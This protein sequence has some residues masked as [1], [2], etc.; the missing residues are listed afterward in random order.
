MAYFAY[1][2]NGIV[3]H[4]HYLDEAN[5]IHEKWIALYRSDVVLKDT[6]G[7]DVMPGDLF[8]EEKFYKKNI[9]TGETSLVEDGV[10]VHP[11]AIRFA[12]I[13]DGELIGQWGV[14][15]EQFESQ[16]KIDEFINDIL[17][18]EIIEIQQDQPHLVQNG[19]TYN[20]SN[21]IEPGNV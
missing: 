1:V 16:E 17:N 21:F 12:G 4:Y 3:K 15:R 13:M 14:G 8:I 19:W 9:E 6:T 11:K 7:Y 18:S 5:P 10:W 20:G 2:R